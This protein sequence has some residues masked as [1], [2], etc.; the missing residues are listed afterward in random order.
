MGDMKPPELE[1]YHC[2][3]HFTKCYI[4]SYRNIWLVILVLQPSSIHGHPAHAPYKSQALRHRLRVFRSGTGGLG[5]FGITFAC[6]ARHGFS[7][8][9]KLP[10]VWMDNIHLPLYTSST[11]QGG[12]GNFKNKKPIGEVGCCEA[13]TAERIHWWIER[14]LELRFLQLDLFFWLCLFSDLL[15]SSLL[16]FDFKTSFDN[17]Q[18]WW[19]NIYNSIYI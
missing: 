7:G 1:D 4:L 2:V 16:K 3:Y 6:R 9:N 17:S 5:H 12:G 14:W 11:T 10:C 8:K 19:F 15:S 13:R 18:K